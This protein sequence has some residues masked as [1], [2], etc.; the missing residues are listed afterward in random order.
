MKYVVEYDTDFWGGDYYG[1]STEFEH[2]TYSEVAKASE[3][4]QEGYNRLPKIARDAIA[5]DIESFAVRV[6]FTTKTNL[7]WEHIVSW[8]VEEEITDDDLPVDT[9]CS[10]LVEE[11]LSIYQKFKE[12][13]GEALSPRDIWSLLNADHRVNQRGHR[14]EPEDLVA[15]I[16]ELAKAPA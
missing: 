3:E 1:N 16:L 8:Y 10:Q 4:C 11:I 7:P 14:V 13:E 12:E 5:P 2:L 6:A 9:D 15:A